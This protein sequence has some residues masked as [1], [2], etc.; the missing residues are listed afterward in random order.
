MTH[1]ATA[2]GDRVSS[3]TAAPADDER[4]L[5]RTPVPSDAE[6]PAHPTDVLVWHW[7]ESAALG[8]YGPPAANFL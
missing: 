5:G 2:R 3:G 4:P 1:P 8:G 6:R 7:A